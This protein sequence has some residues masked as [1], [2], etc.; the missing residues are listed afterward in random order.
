MVKKEMSVED[1]FLREGWGC[2]N[3]MIFIR[4]FLCFGLT[5]KALFQVIL[6]LP[7]VYAD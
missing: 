5:E 3:P 6:G 7:F 4:E 2:V 1:N